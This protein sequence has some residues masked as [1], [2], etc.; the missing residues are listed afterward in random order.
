MRGAIFTLCLSV[1]LGLGFLPFSLSAAWAQ[2]PAPPNALD[3]VVVTAGRSAE[4]LRTIPQPITIIGEEEMQAKNSSDLADALRQKGLQFNPLGAG[5][6]L[7]RVGI[8]GFT[9]TTSPNQTG[10]I[11]ILL[12]GH[13]IGNNNFGQVAIENIERVEILHGPASVQ[14][15]TSAVGGVV[16]LITKR[17]REKLSFFLEESVGSFNARKSLVGFSGRVSALDFSFGASHYAASSYT[18]GQGTLYGKGAATHIEGGQ[19]YPNTGTHSRWSYLANVGFN[20]NENHRIGVIH[21]QYLNEAG[22]SGDYRNFGAVTNPRG[23]GLRSNY[24]TD[25]TYEGAAPPLGLAWLARYFTGQN[26]YVTASDWSAQPKGGYYDYGAEFTGYSA[27]LKWDY[28]VIH[29]TGGFDYYEEEY[30]QINTPPYSSLFSDTAF[31][32]LARAGL[33]SDSLWLSAGVRHDSFSSEGQREPQKTKRNTPSFG[34]AY[35]PLDWLKLRVNYA[36]SFKMPT[37]DRLSG[38]STSSGGIRYIGNPDLKP[39]SAKS[40]DFG[41]D[42]SYESLNAGFTYFLTDYRDR[43]ETRTIQ[44]APGRIDTYRN[45]EGVSKFRGIELNFD[46]DLGYAFQWP[47]KL[48]PYVTLT[49]V[50]TAKEPDGTELETVANLSMA[51]GASFDYPAIGLTASVDVNYFGR[52]KPN[53]GSSM[54]GGIYFG[55][56]TIVDLHVAKDLYDW[57]SKGKLKLKVDVLNVGNR[58]YHLSA[59]YPQPGRAFNASLRYEY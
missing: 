58:F 31:Y 14:Y 30:Y 28:E 59:G 55:K 32:L 12:D 22:R 45:L 18:L 34:V 3:A 56:D 50:F 42:V 39:Q 16:N 15:G 57:E 9:S 21:S 41:F 24:S 11:I 49:R 53:D 6:S 13:P 26:R 35:L 52:Q 48:Q 5:S 23:Y 33:L 54:W 44:P 1:A 2:T 25:V 38:D 43:V 20:V 37:P 46:W 29:L 40:W 36:E 10:D 47:F 8:R 4:E 51:Y 7:T 27:S 19:V 17:G